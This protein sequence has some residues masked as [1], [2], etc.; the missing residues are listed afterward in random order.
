LTDKTKQCCFIQTNKEEC[1]SSP[2]PLSDIANI[3]NSKEFKPLARKIVGYGKYTSVDHPI[4]IK[5]ENMHVVCLDGELDIN[6]REEK[7]SD[8]DLNILKSSDYCLN[9][10]VSN[11]MN[12]IIQ[13]P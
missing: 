1:D 9:Y 8:D 6:I 2:N 4:N 10:T 12:I 13:Q 5:D 7:Y 11:N 3:V